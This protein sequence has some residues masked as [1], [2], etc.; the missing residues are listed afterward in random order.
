[1]FKHGVIKFQRNLH[2]TLKVLSIV[3]KMYYVNGWN[4]STSKSVDVIWNKYDLGNNILAMI[5]WERFEI[6]VVNI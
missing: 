2:C 4:S 3:V 5:L 6:I 1:M